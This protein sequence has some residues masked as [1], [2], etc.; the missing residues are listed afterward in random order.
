MNKNKFCAVILAAG[1][2]TRMN[3]KQTT[4]TLLNLIDKETISTY[5]GTEL[6][7]KRS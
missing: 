1:K 2:D 7:T 6:D 5:T 3:R 4:I